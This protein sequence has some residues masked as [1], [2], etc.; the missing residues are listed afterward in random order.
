MEDH[1]Q[2]IY[3]LDNAANL[4]PAIR[5]KKRPSI[6]RVSAALFEPVDPEKL[7]KALDSTLK[8]FP[9][10][11]VKLRAGLFWHYFIHSDQNIPIQKDVLNPCM[12]MTMKST[13]GFLIRVRYYRNKIALEA[14]HAI[15]DGAGAMVFLKTLL[16]QYLKLSGFYIPATHGVLDCEKLSETAEFADQFHSFAQNS[17][18]RK[19]PRTRAYHIKGTN[20]GPYEMKI[21]TGTMPINALKHTAKLFDATITEYLTAIYMKIICDHQNT[22]AFKLKLPVKVQVPVNLRN[23]QNSKTLRNFS[24]FVSP[25]IDPAHGK[26]DFPEI[27]ALVHHF[28]RYESTKKHLQSQV[29]ANL[30]YA[31]NPM[32]RILPLGLK[33]NLIFLGYKLMGP[34]YFTTTFSNLGMVNVPVE[35]EKHIQSFSLILGATE[36]TSISAGAIG[37]KDHV[38]IAFSRIIQETDV[39]RRF[40]RFLIEHGI[41]VRVESYPED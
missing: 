24:A 27:V 26:Y 8:R 9:G 11:S 28:L 15:T 37:Y 12:H 41:P 32:I 25:S 20:L 5:N 29:A 10:F 34:A 2:L 21:I 4:Y 6:F 7:Q 31:N 22:Q 40:F 36:G 33:N 17:P 14:F 16:A 35:M 1:Q 38:R 13:G 30:R 19:M 3:R 18:I 39:E 23:Y